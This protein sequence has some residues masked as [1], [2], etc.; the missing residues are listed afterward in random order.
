MHSKIDRLTN[1]IDRLV[2]EMHGI[3]TGE[4]DEAFAR[5]G[6]FGC[7]ADLPSVK[8]DAALIY[9]LTA[10]AIGLQLGFRASEVGVL[11]GKRGL[12]WADN[13]DYQEVTRR[14]RPSSQRYWIGDMVARLTKVLDANDPGALGIQH[15]AVIAVFRKWRE[16]RNKQIAST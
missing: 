16:L 15:K 10:T 3:R 6:G 2:S 8:P 9:S 4:K 7:T 11:L 14:T 1:G 13:A 5:V 12:G